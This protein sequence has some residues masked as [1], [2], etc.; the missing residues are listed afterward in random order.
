MDCFLSAPLPGVFG[1]YILF[2]GTVANEVVFVN[3][4]FLILVMD[5][6]DFLSELFSV[7]SE[8]SVI[9]L[10]PSDELD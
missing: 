3:G 5:S 8:C 6:L 7:I 1:Y 4:F 2:G 9:K 10:R